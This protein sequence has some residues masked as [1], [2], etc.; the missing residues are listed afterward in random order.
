MLKSLFGK[1]FHFYL[2]YYYSFFI[3]DFI[4]YMS[5]SIFT[6]LFSFLR[7]LCTQRQT[8]M[9][10]ASSKVPVNSDTYQTQ[11]NSC[12]LGPWAK[13]NS[14]IVNFNSNSQQE[15]VPHW[16]LTFAFFVSPKHNTKRNKHLLLS[17]CGRKRAVQLLINRLSVHFTR[18][19]H[20][21][22]YK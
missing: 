16:E 12:G 2:N 4:W 13:I 22:L 14:M 3:Q 19:F 21:Y 9:L 1:I 10:A 7:A 18:V 11:R 8:E 17:N 20:T 6:F 15:I 5:L